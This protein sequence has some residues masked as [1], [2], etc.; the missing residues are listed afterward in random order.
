[1][2]KVWGRQLH[3]SVLPPRGLGECNGLVRGAWRQSLQSSPCT[4]HRRSSETGNISPTPSRKNIYY[5]LLVRQ[6]GRKVISPPFSNQ[7]CAP[8][9]LAHAS[10]H[11]SD[12]VG[13]WM[14]TW[15]V[16]TL[17]MRK[18]PRGVI[19]LH[20]L[21]RQIKAMGRHFCTRYTG[22]YKNQ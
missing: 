1:M 4:D 19:N 13:P 3:P 9:G 18:T 6:G 2:V 14:L 15:S 16:L 20:V 7:P 5:I 22:V 10:C 21:L 17:Y 12:R 8:K 11:N